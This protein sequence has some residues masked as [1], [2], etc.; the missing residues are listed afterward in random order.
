MAVPDLQIAELTGDDPVAAHRIGQEPG[1][2][3]TCL[4]RQQIT[5]GDHTEGPVEQRGGG[6][7]RGILAEDQVVGRLAAPQ[8]GVVHT[9][10][11]VEYQRGGMDHFNRAR[12]VECLIIGRTEI[13]GNL[14]GE[15]RPDPFPTREQAV[16]HGLVERTRIGGLIGDELGEALVDP[17]TPKQ[18]GIPLIVLPRG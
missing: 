6:E 15:D 9:R 14:N 13:G 5:L 16:T 4:G 1:Q 12:R 17:A 3:E 11:I 2:V 10:K 7:D 18:A 8:A